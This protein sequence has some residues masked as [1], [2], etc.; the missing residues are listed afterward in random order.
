MIKVMEAISR[1]AIPM[2][3][4]V[5]PLWGVVRGVKVYEA[6]VEGAKQGLLTT[7]RIT[8]YL[9]A[10]FVA[11]RVF[12]V[13]GG[14]DLLLQ[15]IASPL[16]LLGIPPEVV[17]MLLIRPLSGSGALSMLR[18]LLHVHGPDSLIGLMA[19]TI[20]GSTE[21]TFYVITVYFGAINITRAR[22]SLPIGLWADF[23]GFIA[24]IYACLWLFG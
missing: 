4:L 12:Q 20:Q 15:V 10:M 16:R 21:T 8:P 6:F 19:A 18:E 2:V 3:V 23:V 5:I 1:W 24:A 17:P 13:A 9:I 14:I 7:V 22:H 11:I